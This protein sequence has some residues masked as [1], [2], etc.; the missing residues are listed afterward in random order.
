VLAPVLGLKPG[1]GAI[2][3]SAEAEVDVVGDG[4]GTDDDHADVLVRACAHRLVDGLK[5]GDGYLVVKMTMMVLLLLLLLVLV[6]SAGPYVDVH[7]Y[8]HFR[9]CVNRDE[10]MWTEMR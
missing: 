6:M 1:S 2:R 7:G 4:D 5:C 9:V 8:L 10:N 3:G